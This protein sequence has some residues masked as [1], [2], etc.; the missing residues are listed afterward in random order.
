MSIIRENLLISMTLYSKTL[1]NKVG[2]FNFKKIINIADNRNK[3]DDSQY[4][5]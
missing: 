5:D 2:S 1:I 4:R 3:F